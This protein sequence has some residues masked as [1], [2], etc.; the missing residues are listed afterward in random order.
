MD[1]KLF[2]VCDI[3]NYNA[4]FD[5]SL[6]GDIS[7]KI[8]FLLSNF[9]DYIT[10]QEKNIN[11]IGYNSFIIKRGFETIK[12]CFEILLLYTKNSNLALFNTKKAYIYYVEFIG[13]IGYNNHSFLKLNSIDA[14]I[15]VYKKTIFEIDNGIKKKYVE[16]D[17]E[18]KHFSFLSHVIDLYILFYK[19]LISK[20]K[21][22]NEDDRVKQIYVISNN[23][24]KILS[25]IYNKTDTIEQNIENIENISLLINYMDE[26]FELNE[27]FLINIVGAF[28]KKTKK[29][30]LSK[31][32]L[33]NKL[34]NHAQVQTYIN[35]QDHN[36]LVNNIFSK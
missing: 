8:L 29:N 25:S 33:Y 22:T 7:K 32:K 18:K 2:N 3:Q 16:D 12:H 35:D 19:I 36:K 5:K 17:I 31:K 9:V 13:Q 30:K 14:T 1:T 28:I 27:Y 4:S 26:N 20:I 23:C 21:T 11:N 10:E 15:F 24:C 34:T 6:T